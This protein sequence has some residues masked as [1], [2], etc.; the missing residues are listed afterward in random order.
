MEKARQRLAHVRVSRRKRRT[1]QGQFRMAALVAAHLRKLLARDDY[2]GFSKIFSALEIFCQDNKLTFPSRATIY[3]FMRQDPGRRYL[4]Q[5][6]PHEVQAALYNQA[7]RG[8]ITGA[9]LVFY[10]FNYG[11]LAA[12]SFA[13]SLP[14]LALY[15]AVKIRGWRPKSLGLLKAVLTARKINHV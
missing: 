11:N 3:K 6:L 8:R 10:C 9:Q 15:Q 12:I 14:W 2:P 5:K 7:P 13:A 1:D 4:I